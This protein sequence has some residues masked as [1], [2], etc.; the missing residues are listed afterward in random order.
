MYC[1]RVPFLFTMLLLFCGLGAAQ[2]AGV[3]NVPFMQVGRLTSQPIGHHDLCIRIPIE[4]QEKTV[5]RSEM[6][7]TPVR[8][9]ELIAVNDGVNTAITPETDMDNYGQ[10]E[11]WAYPDDGKG[12]C[13]DFVLLKRRK[14]MQLGWAAGSLLISVVRQTN[15]DGHAVLT[16]HTDRGDLILDNLEGTIKLWS[17]TDYQYVKRQSDRDSSQWV[18]IT[19][20]RAVLVGSIRP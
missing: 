7:L 11:Y 2:A 17:D 13:E 4:C 12:D 6:H 14:L 8:W 9:A 5:G 3:S 16:V 18:S 1:V 20:D 10:E 19:D 15:G